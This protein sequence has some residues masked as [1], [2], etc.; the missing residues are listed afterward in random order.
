MKIIGLDGKE[1]SWIPSNNIVETEKRSGLHNK[2]QQLL[3]EKYPNDA[4][5]AR[6]VRKL[7]IDG[8]LGKLISDTP[9]DLELGGKLREEKF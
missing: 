5:F 2:A 1:Y 4:E 9:N 3:K 6:E 8:R 7:T